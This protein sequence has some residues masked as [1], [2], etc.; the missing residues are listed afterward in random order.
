MLEVTKDTNLFI[1]VK[2]KDVTVDDVKKYFFIMPEKFKKILE[3]ED[4]IELL[5]DILKNK[6]YNILKYVVNLIEELNIKIDPLKLVNSVINYDA[7]MIQEIIQYFDISKVFYRYQR[8][9]Y[10]K[11]VFGTDLLDDKLAKLYVLINNPKGGFSVY[12]IYKTRNN[13]EY[14][15]LGFFLKSTNI[16]GFKH[17][18][19]K[20]D[21]DVDY[22]EE[23]GY[24]LLHIALQYNNY[25]GTKYLIEKGANVK[26][27]LDESY[28]YLYYIYEYI[29][30]VTDKIKYIKLFIE[31]GLDIDS[32]VNN[33]KYSLLMHSID[34]NNKEMVDFLLENNANVNYE[35][36]N[37]MTPLGIALSPI[38]KDI[39]SNKYFIKKLIDKNVDVNKL[40]SVK[41]HSALFLAIQDKVDLEIV[42]MLI[43]A[44]ADKEYKVPEINN[45]TVLEYAL[46]EY[47]SD[48]KYFSKVIELLGGKVPNTQKWKG[49][50]RS[51]IE[52]L[53]L[54][55]EKPFDWS[56]CPICLEYVERSDGCMY[57][58]HDC[59]KTDHYYHEDLY[60]KFKH[61]YY[62]R[63]QVE[64]CTVCGRITNNHR[65]FK[66][67]LANDPK[68]EFAPVNKEIREQID[69]GD[70]IAF[71]DN[72]NCIGFGGGGTEEK[73][74]RFRRFREYALELQEDV[75]KKEHDEIMEELVEEVW[76]SPLIR[77]R[78]IKK[79]L[80]DKK[81]NINVKEF[82]ED[83]KNSRNTRTNNNTNAPNIPF[84]GTKPTV[85]DDDC[86]IMAEDDSANTR[87]TNPKFHFHHSTVG[88]IN[89][90]GIYI[91]QK[92]LAK[93]I[94]IK[95]AEFGLEN[96][97][98]CWFS[99]CR[100]V[101]HPE[102][103]KNIIPEVLYNDYRK[104]FNKK[105]KQKGGTRK[106]RK[107]QRGGN[108]ESV[109]HELKDGTCI[110]HNFRRDG[111]LRK[112]KN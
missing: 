31:N 62:G 69:R 25:N 5:I 26:F 95:C 40:I 35:S 56:H 17:L 8:N 98:Y 29:T 96:F 33:L 7:V 73:A 84:N 2:N 45:K 67:T 107:Q 77:S 49:F 70:N 1:L 61:N 111:K 10:E 72:A 30:S 85:V 41:K 92:D 48:K 24:P 22:K 55:F 19:Q 58:S 42:K 88:G 38:D 102:E 100:G 52:K 76:N 71:F 68:L 79:I 39:N 3:S 13:N 23:D 59:A 46:Q 4:N 12:E 90:D 81:W 82:P 108:S 112:Y 94:Q 28:S 74:T 27:L 66:L 78:K 20:F 75:G 87:E 36:S 109:L 44:G 101:L 32:S 34:D 110:P 83:K 53:D 65:H 105:M 43:D 47:K 18:M 6:K 15:I 63:I 80:E 57:M 11:I 51:D 50:S 103:L 64:W 37:D 60:N 54:F 9:I 16:E 14:S 104:K 21:I 86:I 97:G 91:C 89:H 106:L 93:A 99:Q